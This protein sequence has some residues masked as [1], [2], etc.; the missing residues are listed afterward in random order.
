M[1]WYPEPGGSPHLAPSCCQQR[2]L[3][4]VLGENGGTR[5]VPAGN[6]HQGGTVG[7][8]CAPVPSHWGNLSSQPEPAFLVPH[9]EA[10]G[11]PA[12]A[13]LDLGI[14]HNGSVSIPRLLAAPDLQ[15]ITELLPGP[16]EE[17]TILLGCHS[18][19]KPSKQIPLGDVIVLQLS[20]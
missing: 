8:I 16:P 10:R 1:F 9:M 3:K 5:Q 20:N 11:F 2:P 14:H 15:L 7:L 13:R 19:T 6:L 18:S 17:A 12:V 4:P